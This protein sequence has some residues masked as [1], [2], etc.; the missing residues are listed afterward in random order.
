LR[1]KYRHGH[2]VKSERKNNDG[3]LISISVW[4]LWEA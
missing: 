3:N 4:R 2:E 1:Y